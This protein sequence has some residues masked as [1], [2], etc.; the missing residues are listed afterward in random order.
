MGSPHI[1]KIKESAVVKLAPG[2]IIVATNLAG[3]G[4]DP[5]TTKELNMDSKG[6]HV[7]QTFLP[8]NQRVEDQASG[9]SKSKMI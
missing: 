1:V 3:L 7:A 6:M 5:R 8:K 2:D 4:P 9:I